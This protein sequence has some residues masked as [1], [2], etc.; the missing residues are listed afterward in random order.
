[1]PKKTIFNIPSL[2]G[3]IIIGEDF[4]EVTL[5]QSRH[6]LRFPIPVEINNDKRGYQVKYTLPEDNNLFVW[7]YGNDIQTAMEMFVKGVSDYYDKSESSTISTDRKIG[8]Y[9][10]SIIAN[11]S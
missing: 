11:H 7:G 6:I 1:M 9:L 3:K 2:E 4:G 5:P 8:M 10:R